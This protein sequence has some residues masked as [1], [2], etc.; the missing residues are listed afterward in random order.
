MYGHPNSGKGGSYHTLDDGTE[1][2]VSDDERRQ[3]EREDREAEKRASKCRAEQE[4]LA[5]CSHS[6]T[7]TR[8]LPCGDI[9]TVCNTCHA[10]LS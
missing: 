1:I 5:S 2:F 3:S 4:R 7:R 10:V 8:H 9:E 6:S